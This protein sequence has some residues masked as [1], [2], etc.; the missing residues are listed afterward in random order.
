M[1]TDYLEKLT[2]E[3]KFRC[4]KGLKKRMKTIAKCKR[5]KY[6]ALARDVI[7]SF[8]EAEELKVAKGS[9]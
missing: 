4:E 6:Q 8:V 2:D 7:Y 3:I 5:K 9:K 1:T